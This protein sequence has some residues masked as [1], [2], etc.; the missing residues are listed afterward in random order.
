M[1]MRALWSI[2]HLRY[3]CHSNVHVYNN[4][5]TTKKVLFENNNFK[6]GINQIKS[7]NVTRSVKIDHLQ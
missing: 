1:T 4:I 2:W 3:G 7:H 6:S 5:T